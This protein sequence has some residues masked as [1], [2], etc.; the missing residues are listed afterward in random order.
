MWLHRTLTAAALVMAGLAGIST[1]TRPGA[2]PGGAASPAI[3]ENDAH[4][5]P[6]PAPP[7][8]RRELVAQVVPPTSPYSYGALR[9]VLIEDAAGALDAVPLRSGPPGSAGTADVPSLAD[10]LRAQRGL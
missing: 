7:A 1:L 8:P 10:L 5:Q 6:H 4:P 2:Q 3:V 9:D